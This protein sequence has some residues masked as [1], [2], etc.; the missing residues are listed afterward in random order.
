MKEKVGAFYTSEIEKHTQELQKLKKQLLASSTIRLLLFLLI[1]FGLYLFFGNTKIII[2]TIV[3]GIA[4]FL[5]LV[6]RH[7]KL[8]YK[9][10]L[11]IA[12]I[13]QN[14]TELEVLNRT[15]HH[16]PNGDTYKDAAHE[17]SQDIDLF[18]R[19][20]FYQYL[21]RTA[22]KS[23]SD[24]LAFLLTENAITQ[25]PQKQE[26]IKE[27]AEKPQWRHRFSAIASLVK[28]ETT[29]TKVTN[30]LQGYSS[31]VPKWMPQVSLLF[32]IL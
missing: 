24:A 6:T 11:I 22:L 18:G 16:L 10:D 21:N 19:G 17:Y 14:K 31:F 23:G 30:W 9:R 27:L 2:A 7:S 25:I 26:S 32:S 4:F 13:A 20:S 1:C 15:F 8:Q 28:I 5:F 29:S 3:I 12:I